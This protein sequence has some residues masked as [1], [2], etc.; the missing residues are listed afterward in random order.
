MEEKKEEDK[1]VSKKNKLIIILFIFAL[2]F[3]AFTIFTISSL[4]TARKPA[5]YLYPTE[6]S[7]VNVK[8]KIKGLITKDIPKYNNGWNVFVTKD[9]LINQ[10][11]DY[12]FYETKL[13]KVDLPKSGWVVKY[14]D[15]NQWF[16]INLMKLGLNEKEKKQFIE[17][18]IESLPE[19]NYYEIKLLEEN[20][21]NENMALGISPKPD[22]VIRLMF[23]F[24]PLNKKIDITEPDINTPKREG[25][26]VVEWGG[27]LDN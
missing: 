17:Y 22:T 5:I 14:K 4:G 26:T 6:D 13:L 7:F 18:W 11:Y 25:F 21:L 16:D 15:L 23:N 24:R 12:L 8:L 3:T 20:F 2:L 19:A 27:I 10:K 9:G 1:K